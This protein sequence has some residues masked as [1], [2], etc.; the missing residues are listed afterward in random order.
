ME[1]TR[2]EKLERLRKLERLQ[3]LQ[4][5]KAADDEGTTLVGLAQSFNKGLVDLANLPFHIVNLFSTV[6]GKAVGSELP[7]VP[8]DKI[9]Q[10]LAAQGFLA[11]PGKEQ[12]GFLNR[13]A[14]ILGASV[15]PSAAIQ[16]VGSNVL[17]AGIPV[18]Q[19]TVGQQLA[20]ATASSPGT[21][22]FLDVASSGGAGLGGEVASKMTDDPSMIVLGELAGGFTLPAVSAVMRV[23]GKPAISKAKEVFTPFTK[24]GAEPRAARRLQG[25]SAD[26]VAEA[27][28]IDVT[29]PVSPARQT[30]NPR[31]IALERTVLE[32]NPELEAK[33][34]KELNGALDAARAR[35][36][37]FGGTD[38]T[39]EIL[40]R[41]QTHLVELVKLRAARA[42]QV[43]QSEIEALGGSVTPRDLSRIARTQLDAALNDVR[44]AENTL[45]E[46]VNKDAPANFSRTKAALSAID[47]ETGK[48]VPSRVP[49]WLQKAVLTTKPVAF[50][51]LQSIRS[52]ILADAREATNKGK[53]DKARVLNEA[54]DGLLADM[55]VVNDPNVKTAQA[56][57]AALN[58][59]FNKGAVRGVLSR[60][61][62]R[63]AGVAAEDTLE[64][65]F[66]GGTAATNVRSFLDA[67]P[68]SA[69][70]VMQYIKAKFARTATKTGTY[71][72]ALA[73][74][75][76]DKL[77]QQGMFEVFPEL[78]GELDNVSGLFQKARQLSER[79]AT[80][81]ARGGSR[82]QQDSNKSLAGVLLGAEPGQEI[83]TLLRSENPTVMAAA[84][85]RRMGTNT[86]AAKGLKTSFVETLFD[87]ASKTGSTGEVEV[88]GQKLATLVNDN[89]ATAKAIGLDDADITRMKAIARQMI[90][91][92]ADTGGSVGAILED[93]PAELLQ[94]VAQI[95]GAKVGQR[96]AGSGLG[97]SMVIAGKGSGIAT[98]L[99]QKVTTN[100]A[101]E[102]LIAAQSDPVLY[103]AL[104][105]KTTA[106]PTD[107]FAA[108]RIIESWLIGAG[109]EAGNN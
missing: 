85:K 31:L 73:K 76:A 87:Q 64:Q 65:L 100:K 51:D 50:K 17:K 40:E 55:S 13:S 53:F 93:K 20:A 98:R 36:A 84:L 79:A 69:P 27:N 90:Q 82:L 15:L 19:R 32:Q 22:A 3:V 58:Q 108:T 106:K 97:S 21:A 18:A 107:I 47:A 8:I 77:E 41:G 88:S 56:F 39:R 78:K 26:P 59:T 28:L 29:S 81:G 71:S 95:A 54:A 68:E 70:Q 63:G 89:I 10:S 61:A 104:L 66:S 37:E 11:E 2:E 60:G 38:R 102:L 4:A 74:A 57:S 99:L 105:T 80:V 30:G 14:E 46:R 42:A 62:N 92:Q 67:S 49:T 72:P 23:A 48:L 86:D 9:N 1:M 25:L 109:V 33:F 91:A 5:Q 35:A 12:Q 101:Q 83:A 16:M 94:F 43:A 96:I 34:T 45:W 6:A 52:R 103:R 7:K 44:K 75:Y 24:A